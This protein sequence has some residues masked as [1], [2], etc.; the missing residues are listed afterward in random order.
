M[1][2]LGSAA[3]AAA[4]VLGHAPLAHA[5]CMV[6]PPICEGFWSYD[7]IFDGTVSS[8]ERRDLPFVSG[9][10]TNIPYQLVTVSVNK[11][12]R[13]TEKS[14]EQ[15]LVAGGYGT[16]V[17]DAFRFESGRRYLIFAR[18][19]PDGLLTTSECTPT[20]NI[21]ERTAAIDELDRL[22]APSGA[23]WIQGSVFL[24]AHDLH[25]GTYQRTPLA[26]EV[27][28]D[29]SA[30]IARTTMS[31]SGRF[32]FEGLAP[33]PY[34]VSVKAPAHT[35][36]TDT[37]RVVTLAHAPG[38]ASVDF[39]LKPD[40]RI[41]GVAV[42]AD[43]TPY[44]HGQV[45]LASADSATRR[46]DMATVV[47]DDFGGFTF[48]GLSPGSYTAGVDLRDAPSDSSPYPRVA[49]ASGD[50]PFVIRVE[51]GTHVD[52]G[53]LRLPA[54]LQKV[55]VSGTVRFASGAPVAHASVTAWTRTA[56]SQWA[57]VAGTLSSGDGTFTLNV[58]SGR[59]VQLR[60]RRPNARQQVSA[61]VDVPAVR[62]D[63]SV[64]IM[65]PDGFS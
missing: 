39:V 28:L 62:S 22:S 15:L 21:A 53:V 24:Q 19:R 55:A 14:T 49:Y 11:A 46:P 31:S 44:A 38:C 33:G 23:G 61:T 57:S 34:T 29:G 47:T 20:G 1:R 30:G 6:P 25:A 32:R 40:G 60:V 26:I 51:P 5:L 63:Q 16:W 18:R 65:I 4:C 12:W 64:S 13:G 48:D 35:E 54:A 17:E 7:A 59:A 37:Q 56:D 43:G 8:I 52:L 41:T 50:A 27:H 9:T 58:W 36:G 3:F 45:D 10:D 2:L 42:L